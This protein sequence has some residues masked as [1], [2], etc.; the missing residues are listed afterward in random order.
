MQ[1]LLLIAGLLI[2]SACLTTVDQRWCDSQT[3]CTAGF[4]CTSTFHCIPGTPP[5]DAGV[6]GGAGGGGGLP[7]GGG[8]VN[9]GGGAGGG[10]QPVGG[11]GGRSC[12]AT[13]LG[14]CFNSQCIQPEQQSQAVCGV[15][16]KQ[17]VSCALSEACTPRAGCLPVVISDGGV[18][19]APGSPCEDDFE[20]GAD[21]QGQ[22]IPEFSGGEFTGWPDGYCTRS[23]DIASCPSGSNCVEADSGGQPI[24]ICLAACQTDAQCRAGYA[25]AV[26]EED[27][28]CIPE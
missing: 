10:G 16:G 7:V 20:C 19:G 3:P 22:C 23:C 14:C 9:V 17:C 25:C 2:S 18:G 4:V 12:E 24:F 15:G 13:C 26:A 6:G 21:G 1:R 5:R 11:G 27:G 8:G 28:F